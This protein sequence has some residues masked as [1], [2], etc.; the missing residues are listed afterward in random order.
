MKYK[1]QLQTILTH[2]KQFKC[3]YQT[4]L[5]FWYKNICA[6]SNEEKKEILK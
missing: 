2:S 3:G 4:G 6:T 1:L 5:I